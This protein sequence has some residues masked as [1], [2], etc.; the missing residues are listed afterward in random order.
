[1]VI[2]VGI[3]VYLQLKSVTKKFEQCQVRALC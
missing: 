3:N 2:S 1:M